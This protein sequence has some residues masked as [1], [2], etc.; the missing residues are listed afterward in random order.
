M[1]GLLEEDVLE[2]GC[3]MLGEGKVLRHEASVWRLSRAG[4]RTRAKRRAVV[5][6]GWAGKEDRGGKHLGTAFSIITC[7]PFKNS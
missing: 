4:G 6:I 7:L 3:G 1:S 2:S 5:E